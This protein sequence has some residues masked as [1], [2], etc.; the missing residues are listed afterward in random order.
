MNVFATLLSSTCSIARGAGCH[1]AG[2]LSPTFAPI[3]SLL[4][5]CCKHFGSG[6]G[7]NLPRG[8]SA[9]S[10]RILHPASLPAAGRAE[11]GRILL[12]H[13]KGKTV[14]SF[15]A[16]SCRYLGHNPRFREVR[17]K[18]PSDGSGHW[19]RPRSSRATWL[20]SVPL[21]SSIG[22]LVWVGLLAYLSVC[23]IRL[24]EFTYFRTHSKCKN[25]EEREKKIIIIWGVK[26]TMFLTC[27]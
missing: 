13:T 16:Q 4:S 10:I 3:R 11:L 14:V 25:T 27:K 15:R 9:G 20:V 22:Q 24:L 26:N 7:Q 21:L 5:P 17:R 12:T 23:R 6:G 19:I 18:L 8:L 2:S 1:A